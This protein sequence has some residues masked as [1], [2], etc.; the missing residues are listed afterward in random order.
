MNENAP[1]KTTKRA[2]LGAVGPTA[3]RVPHEAARA[4]IV[5]ILRAWGV[6]AAHADAAGEL[7]TYADLRGIE[8]HGLAMMANYETHKGQGSFVPAPE[9]TLVRETPA[10]ALLD[11]GAG[12]GHHPAIRGMALAIEKCAKIGIAAV[13][14]RNSWHFG[15]AGYYA[16]MAVKRG[17]IG[18]VTTSVWNNAVV[19]TYAAEAMLGTNP[20]A[21]AAPARRNPPFVFD[22]ASSTVAAGKVQLAAILG[23]PIPVGWSVNDRGEPETDSQRAWDHRALTPLGGTPEMSSHKGYGLGAMVEI[24]SGTLS[25]ARHAAVEKHHGRNQRPFNV[26]H[27][28]LAIDPAAMRGD[29]GFADQLD[30]LIDALRAAKPVDPRQPVLVAGDPERTKHA[31]RSREGIPYAPALVERVRKMADAAGC[32]YMLEGAHSEVGQ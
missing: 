22:M 7:L 10:L 2:A 8:S 5:A 21:L 13:T 14:V 11:G 27:F 23:K 12:M 24:L 25:G 30:E 31:E 18:M 1:Q 4:Q 16:E 6:G 29:D 26:G 20:I 3:I 15:A 28:F 9:V 19:P 32:D 17:L